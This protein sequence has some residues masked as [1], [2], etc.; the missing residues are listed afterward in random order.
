MQPKVIFVHGAGGG[1]WEWAIWARVFEAEGWKCWAPSLEPV[2][3]G[4]EATRFGDY[5]DQLV[6]WLEES[7]ATRVIAASLG[8][9]LALD[10]CSRPGSTCRDLLLINPMVPAALSGRAAR[11]WP[12]VVPWGRRRPLAS[13]RRAIS[14]GDAATWMFAQARWRD[15]S[16][17]VLKAAEGM[18]VPRPACRIRVT[19]GECDRDSPPSALQALATALAAPLELLDGADHLDALM[20]RPAA[21]LA[22]REVLAASTCSDWAGIMEVQVPVDGGRSNP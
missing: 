12:G 4:L 14:M 19:G 3:V 8:A 13:T 2:A 21:T 10:A 15:E 7:Q 9:L 22:R 11:D 16:G 6:Q 20:G 18:S 17:A 1:G 5:V